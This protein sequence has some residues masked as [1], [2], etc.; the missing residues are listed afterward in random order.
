MIDDPR[1]FRVLRPGGE[2]VFKLLLKC[3]DGDGRLDPELVRLEGVRDLITSDEDGYRATVATLGRS[4]SALQAVGADL[5]DGIETGDLRAVLG[6][7]RRQSFREIGTSSR[8]AYARVSTRLCPF[9]GRTTGR[10]E[11][12]GPQKLLDS[13]RPVWPPT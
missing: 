7:F 9:L 8:A 6:N 10:G 4:A 12:A 2:A 3:V 13:H 1:G 5:V 11:A